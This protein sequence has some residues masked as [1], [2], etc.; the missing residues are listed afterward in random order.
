MDV[1][2]KP[3]NG[4]QS[5]T[6]QPD[7]S[8][9]AFQAFQC[10]RDMN[11]D[12]STAA[13]ARALSKSKSLMDRWCSRHAWV[14]RCRAFDLWED[15]RLREENVRARRDMMRR[16][17]AQAMLLQKVATNS[18]KKFG[19]NPNLS[20]TEAVHALDVGARL[21]MRSRGEPE[22]GEVA[23]VVINVSHRPPE[24]HVPG[25]SKPIPI[26]A[27]GGNNK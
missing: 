12:R 3:P 5:W 20:P 1:Q 24:P 6:Q 11:A 21:E 4:K 8:T 15:D 26:K 9:P 19:D 25:L 7:E 23:S 27:T 10:Y 17:S 18:I 13:V 2:N 22:S 14:E 16:I